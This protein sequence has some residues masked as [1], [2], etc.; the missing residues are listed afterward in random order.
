[1]ILSAR[2]RRCRATLFECRPPLRLERERASER[3]QRVAGRHRPSLAGGWAE[4]ETQN[5]RRSRAENLVQARRL[6][7]PP[8]PPPSAQVAAA[9]HSKTS[10]PRSRPRSCQASQPASRPALKR[11]IKQAL[12]LAT[13][14]P[15]ARA[16][17]DAC[18]AA[19]IW[20]SHTSGAEQFGANSAH[21]RRGQ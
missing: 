12:R 20:P 15:G 6:H 17:P 11:S 21:P 13:R 2:R 18:Q 9:T 16:P 3:A 4:N 14:P 19:P 5:S 10:R 8:L 7:R 1:M